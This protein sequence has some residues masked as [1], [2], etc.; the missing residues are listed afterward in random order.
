MAWRR[1]AQ[2]GSDPSELDARNAGEARG[3]RAETYRFHFLGLEG[4]KTLSLK[5]SKL[6]GLKNSFLSLRLKA[7]KIEVRMIERFIEL[8]IV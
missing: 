5:A 4:L 3:G 8:W 6:K 1:A 2:D 7:R